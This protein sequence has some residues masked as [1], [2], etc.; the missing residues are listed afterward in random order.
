MFSL[1]CESLVIIFYFGACQKEGNHRVAKNLCECLVGN[2]IN[3]F[4]LLFARSLRFS[5]A[6]YEIWNHFRQ[7]YLLKYTI[8]GFG[9][10]SF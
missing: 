8:D 4:L 5:M 10:L 7:E 3:H 9:H 6:S 1:T 2:S